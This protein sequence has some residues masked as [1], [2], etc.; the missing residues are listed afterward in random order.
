MKIFFLNTFFF[1]LLSFL[2]SVIIWGFDIALY[3]TTFMTVFFTVSHPFTFLFKKYELR[4]KLLIYPLVIALTSFGQILLCSFIYVPIV[5]PVFLFISGLFPIG[6]FGYTA[7]FVFSGTTVALSM[8]LVG[9][10]QIILTRIRLANKSELSPTPP[11]SG[12]R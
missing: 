7:L 1:V 3:N 10:T 2:I 12:T 8:L 11:S 5:T 4:H 9:I 6:H